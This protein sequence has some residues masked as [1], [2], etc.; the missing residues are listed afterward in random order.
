LRGRFVPKLAR[1]R[2]QIV[3]AEERTAREQSQYAEKKMQAAISIGAT[4]VGALFGRKLGS[5][6]S[7][8][9]AATAARGV[10]RA[11]NEREDIARAAERVEDLR[12]RLVA[13]ERD[14][15]AE[16][17]QLEVAVDPATLPLE[18]TSIAPRKSDI[19]VHP[20][21]LVWVPERSA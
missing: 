12:A 15:E 7:V 1:L 6:T 3:R 4:L 13:L 18:E 14:F 21:S 17:A 16:S 9:R 8:G 10:G 5:A 2:E 11:A 20:L 19:D